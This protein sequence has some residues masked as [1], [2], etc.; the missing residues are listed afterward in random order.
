[1]FDKNLIAQR[2]RV[3]RAER[4]MTQQSL[5]EKSGVARDS[6]IKYEAGEVSMGLEAACRLADVFEVPLD[7]LAGRSTPSKS[8]E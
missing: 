2:M 4:K 5:A 3:L 1:M 7:V 6:I 8:G